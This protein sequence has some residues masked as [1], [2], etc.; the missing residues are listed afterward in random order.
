[1]FKWAIHWEILIFED[2]GLKN[3]YLSFTNNYFEKS[4]G[5]K[6]HSKKSPF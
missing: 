2:F 4:I 1:M 5:K 6:S 3:L